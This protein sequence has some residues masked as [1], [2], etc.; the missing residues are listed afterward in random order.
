MNPDAL[1]TRDAAVG[2]TMLDGLKAE[3]WQFRS[4]PAGHRF[5]ACYERHQAR[6]APWLKPILFFFAIF[7]LVIGLVLAF[8]PGPA[9]LFFAIAAALL[10]AESKIVA[11]TF[12]R[13]ECW[14]H[15]KLMSGRKHRDARATTKALT[16][17]AAAV[18]AARAEI[19]RKENDKTRREDVELPPKRRSAELPAGTPATDAPRADVQQQNAEANPDADQRDAVVPPGAGAEPIVAAVSPRKN[20]VRVAGTMKL[21]ADELPQPKPTKPTARVRRP[22]KQASKPSIRLLPPPMIIGGGKA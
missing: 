17:K 16:P 18:I 10:A 20:P 19:I 8:I 12:D 3:W 1:G 7:S 9:I 15:L 13:V 14:C 5:L 21:W 11:M 22:R 6:E 2:D 4:A